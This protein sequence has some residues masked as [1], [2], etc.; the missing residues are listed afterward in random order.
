MSEKITLD[1]FAAAVGDKVTRLAAEMA[2]ERAEIDARLLARSAPVCLV[3]HELLVLAS[4][5]DGQPPLADL[6]GLSSE[7]FGSQARGVAFGVLHLGLVDGRPLDRAAFVRILGKRRFGGLGRICIDNL[8]AQLDL[9]PVLVGARL[10]HTCRELI[11]VAGLNDL[12][13]ALGVQLAALRAGG[14]LDPVALRA[15]IRGALLPL[16]E[17]LKAVE[18]GS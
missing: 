10:R 5:L 1:D 13:R 3:E 2:I 15:E 7:H 6:C 11:A 17:T 12:H 4:V 9:L 18:E 8:L 14:R 16:G